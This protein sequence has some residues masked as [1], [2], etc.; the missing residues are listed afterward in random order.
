MIGNPRLLFLDEP[1]TGFDPGAR[2]DAW[3]NLRDLRDAGVTIL[4]TTHYM[5]EA[6]ALADRVAVISQG[7]V[8]ATGTP[9]NIGGRETARA[10]IRFALPVGAA[11][12]DL[13]VPALGG[14]DALLTVETR[15]P[16]RVLHLLTGWALQRGVVLDRLAVD[17]PSLEEVYLQL[18]DPSPAGAGDDVAVLTRST[19]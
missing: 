13:P 9:A 3:Q 1:T 4:L 8:V 12:D 5:D 16:T 10:R 14:D 15:E 17:R 7:R 18:T 19:G 6:Q 11:L 2:R